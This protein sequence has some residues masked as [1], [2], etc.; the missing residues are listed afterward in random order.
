MLA[1]FQPRRSLVLGTL[2][3]AFLGMLLTTAP[4]HAVTPAQCA[5]LTALAVPNTT[6]T[7]AALVPA[8][9]GLPEYCRVQGRVD[10]EINFELRLPTQWNGKFLFQ[11]VGGLAGVITPPSAG[12]DGGLPRGYAEVTT[13]TGHQAQARPDLTTPLWDGSWAFNNVERQINWGHRAIHVVSAAAKGITQG[14]YGQPPRLS[15]FIGCS[16]GG[17]QAVMTAERYPMD[18]NGVIAGAPWLTPTLQ[19]V[20]WT[21]AAHALSET[22]V[23]PDKLRL[24]ARTVLAECDGRDGLIDGLIS[25]PRRCRFDPNKL[26]CQAGDGPGCLTEDQVETLLKIY[27]GPVT[28]GGEQLFPGFLPGLEDGWL[29]PAPG[30]IAAIVNDQG[31]YTGTGL[32]LAREFLRGFAFGPTYD[33]LTFDFDG[34]PPLLDAVGDIVNVGPDLSAFEAAGGKMIIYHGWHDPRLSPWWSILYRDAVIRALGGNIHRTDGFLGLFMV[35]GMLHCAGGPGPNTFD[36]LTAL[37]KWV[38][39]GIEP[40]TIVATHRNAAGVIDRTRPLCPYPQ[41][42]VYNGTGSIDDAGSFSCRTRGLDKGGVKSG[43]VQGGAGAHSR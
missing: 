32:L 34:D 36:R 42:A 40:D 30:A 25:D 37:E 41:V 18:F 6:I 27:S 8:G 33:W 10:T 43:G 20:M 23:P 19:V 22:P 31:G 17:R 2:T 4:A 29:A 16:G 7:S 15:Y 13:D 28:S 5:A 1:S 39:H 14:Y 38:E 12:I 21:W 35:P 24:V 3:V 9:G 26:K 11:G